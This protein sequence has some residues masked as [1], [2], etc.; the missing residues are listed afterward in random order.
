[1]GNGF[2]NRWASIWAAVSVLLPCRFFDPNQSLSVSL[3]QPQRL[4]GG[5]LHLGGFRGGSGQVS[6]SGGRRLGSCIAE[7]TSRVFGEFSECL[8]G[9]LEQ[10]AVIFIG[11]TGDISPSAFVKS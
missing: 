2:P 9:F 11:V 3:S 6:H 1:M 5:I 7:R 8:H 10:T 4:I